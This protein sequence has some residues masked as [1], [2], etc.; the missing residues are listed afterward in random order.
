M[1][2]HTGPS[3]PLFIILLLLIVQY[4]YAHLTIPPIFLFTSAKPPTNTL[5]HD[6]TPDRTPPP[7]FFKFYNNFNSWFTSTTSILS[8]H[9]PDPDFFL[10][11]FH[12]YFNSWFT[13][14]RPAPSPT[15]HDPPPPFPT[16]PSPDRPPT[17]TTPAPTFYFNSTITS[18][19]GSHPPDRPF[20]HLS[21]PPPPDLTLQNPPARLYFFAISQ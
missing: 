7:D 13:S 21:R 16:R 12:N 20:P 9:P 14:T 1:W 19:L 3:L 6:P 18:I 8:S 4:L 17:H 10:F 2:V 15:C 11:Q 5:P